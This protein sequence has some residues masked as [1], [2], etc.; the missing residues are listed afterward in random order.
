MIQVVTS[1]SCIRLSCYLR[2]GWLVQVPARLLAISAGV[3]RVVPVVE[4]AGRIPAANHAFRFAL[5]QRELSKKEA[6]TPASQTTRGGQDPSLTTGGQDPSL[7]TDDR[8][9]GPRPHRRR[10]AASP[11]R[12]TASRKPRGRRPGPKPHRRQAA[13]F[14]A[15]F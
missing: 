12:R 3:I 8:R 7:N 11:K 9:P 4:P 13:R 2:R 1:W 10:L 14:Q 15:S 6:R 5:F